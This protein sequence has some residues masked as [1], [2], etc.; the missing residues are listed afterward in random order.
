[1]P[2]VYV[3]TGLQGVEAHTFGTN[4]DAYVVLSGALVARMTEPELA[5]VLG[6]ECGRIQNNHVMYSTALYYLHEHAN[7]FVRWAVAPAVLALESWAR[8]AALTADRAGLL[9]TRDLDV[10]QAALRKLLEGQA[11]EKRA[12]ALAVFAESAYFRG[13]S[14]KEGGLSAAECDAKV[15]ELIK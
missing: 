4:E 13:L 10:S 6:R 5:D 14:Q 7:R 9:C 3:A 1:V 12:Q 15:A 11:A 8:R 2:T